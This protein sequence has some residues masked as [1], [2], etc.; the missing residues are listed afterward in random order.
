[1]KKDY[2]KEISAALFLLLLSLLSFFLLKPILMAIITGII[3]AFLFIPIYNKIK[4][5]IKS[6]DLSTAITSLLLIILV[7][8]PLWFI[9]PILLNQSL[10]IYAL[11]QKINLRPILES[12]FP[13][14]FQNGT[15][16]TEIISA[17]YSFITNL[18]N[19]AINLISEIILKFPTLFLQFLVSFFTFYFVV[20]DHDEFIDYVQTVLPFNK[21]IKDKL[22]KSSKDI[23][24]SVIYGQV[25]LGVI[26]GIF[27]GISFFLFGVN[28]ALFLTMIA[29]LAGIFPIIGTTVIWVPVAIFL[30]IKGSTFSALGVLLFGIIGIFLENAVKPIFISKRT[31]VHSGI[32][33]LGMI[34]GILFF[35]ILGVILG[36]LILSYLLIIL[37]TYRGRNPTG[38]FIKH[39]GEEEEQ[40]MGMF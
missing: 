22:F 6:K 17:L 9:V 38:V 28:Q 4:S 26:Q 37:E 12:I 8:I 31:N 35:G 27:A 16:S 33:L 24:S 3:L 5:K 1:M 13:T 36:P 40:K 34:G 19:G 14:L 7:I 2:E 23:T 11:F 18:T 30:F 29:I 15:F 21:K 39:P 20:R 10:E 25:G 32:I